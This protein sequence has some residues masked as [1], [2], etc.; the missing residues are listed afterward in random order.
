MRWRWRCA[1]GEDDVE[2]MGAGEMV[3]EEKGGAGEIDIGIAVGRVVGGWM[4]E[5]DIDGCVIE[6]DIF[7]TEVDVD[8]ALAPKVVSPDV[9]NLDVVDNSRAW[10]G[11]E[12]GM[13]PDRV[14]VVPVSIEVEGRSEFETSA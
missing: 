6:L 5:V 14:V 8:I 2:G 1:D 12:E 7:V 10:R 4:V 13:M 11:V 3:M 9:G